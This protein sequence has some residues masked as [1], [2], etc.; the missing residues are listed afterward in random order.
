MTILHFSFI[1]CIILVS[2]SIFFLAVV[3]PSMAG[4]VRSIGV[5]LSSTYFSTQRN[6]KYLMSFMSLDF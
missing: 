4:S 6:S 5:I 1:V 2:V 3:E